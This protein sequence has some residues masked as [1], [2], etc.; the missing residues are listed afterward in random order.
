MQRENIFQKYISESQSFKNFSFQKC[1]FMWYI[2][3][4]RVPMYISV[5]IVYTLASC[6]AF[7]YET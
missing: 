6:L 1:P 3:I 4:H 2:Y 5:A 7:T